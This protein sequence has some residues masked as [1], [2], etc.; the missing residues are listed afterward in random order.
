ME[1]E[2]PRV[3]KDRIYLSAKNRIGMDEL[4]HVVK[5]YIFKDYRKCQMLI[6][7]DKGHLI[8]YFNEQANVVETEYEESGTKLTLECKV[9]DFE[10]YQ[11]YIIQ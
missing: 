7:F 10:K 4:L 8:S 3:E 6:P 5:S 1:G 11:Q 2:V 9:S